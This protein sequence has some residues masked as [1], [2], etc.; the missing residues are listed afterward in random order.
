MVNGYNIFNTLGKSLKLFINRL[1]E[2][3]QQEEMLMEVKIVVA[4]LVEMP[5]DHPSSAEL[6]SVPT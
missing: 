4:F 6:V 2:A 1:L 3:E 5:T